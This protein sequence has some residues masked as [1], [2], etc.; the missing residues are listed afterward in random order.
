MAL[1]GRGEA[2]W[3]RSDGA[4]SLAD[5]SEALALTP[6]AAAYHGR[7]RA[8]STRGEF[9]R[10]LADFN[11][12]VQMDARYAPAYLDRG[13]EWLRRGDLDKG[14]ADYGEGVRLRPAGIENILAFVERR[15][16]ELK[17]DRDEA[18][19]E[20]CRR[21]LALAAP[22]FADRVELKKMIDDSLTAATNETDI[23]KRALLLRETILRI[24]SRLVGTS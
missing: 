2:H 17:D 12:A 1:L 14:F 19:A 20:L 10:A 4:A 18:V 21:T 16:T 15:T 22:L 6:D 11:A 5:F 24:R 7:G 8:L 23:R 3:A 9:D 13:G